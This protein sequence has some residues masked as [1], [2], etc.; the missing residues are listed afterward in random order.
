MADWPSGDLATSHEKLSQNETMP[1]TFC[2]ERMKVNSSTKDIRSLLSPR[3]ELET[4]CISGLP[5]LLRCWKTIWTSS[6]ERALPH[7]STAPRCHH[8]PHLPPWCSCDRSSVLSLCIFPAQK[9][10]NGLGWEYWE[11]NTF[12]CAQTL[13]SSGMMPSGP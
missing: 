11:S 12:G 3:L 10:N 1:W 13:G 9:T 5:G 4:N 8:L 6:F 2:G 7:I